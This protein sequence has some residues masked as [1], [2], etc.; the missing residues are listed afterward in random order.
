MEEILYEVF[1]ILPRQGPGSFEATKKAFSCLRNIPGNTKILD[2][3]CGSGK[4]TFDL[5]A[6]TKSEILAID[7]YQGFIDQL[8]EKAKTIG[9]ADRV[10]GETRDM[11]N[12]PYKDNS[13]D[14]IWCEGAIYNI[15]FEKGLNEWNHLLKQ[16]GY[17]ALTEVAW[18][19]ND[20][21]V[22]LKHFFEQEY[23]AIKQY[24]QNIDLIKNAGYK[25]IDSF[26]L[27]DN[28]WR[29][30]YYIPL[31]KQIPIFRKKYAD[32]KEAQDF[33]DSLETEI[34]MFNKY[35]EFYGYVFYIM[36]KK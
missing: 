6:I 7:N 18:L 20:I 19:K 30:D 15:G 24:K 25:L 27:P 5:A 28:T 32:N 11:C 29:D 8:N 21:P 31:E 9:L 1:R 4:Q 35:S 14:I 10:I 34:N 36:Q 23:P 2:I 17:I 3:G 26:I 13:F 22:S 12:L 16:N 33:F